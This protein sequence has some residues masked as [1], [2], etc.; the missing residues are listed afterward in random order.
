MA[1]NLCKIGKTRWGGGRHAGRALMRKQFTHTFKDIISIENLLKA[2]GEFLRG[3]SSRHDVQEFSMH[4]MDNIFS[5]H[6]ELRMHF[7]LHGEYHAFNISDPKPRNIHKA[8]VR[9][10]LLHRALYRE[11]YP[12]FDRTFMADSYSCRLGK[13]THKALNRFQTFGRRTSKNHTKT[14]WVLKCDVRKFFAPVDQE[15]LIC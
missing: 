10:R 5:L 4:L 1:V 14:V 9:D 15:I 2:W 6:D 7:Y 13:G 3:K 8:S 11:L 12:F